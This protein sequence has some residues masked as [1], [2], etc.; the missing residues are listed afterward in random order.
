MPELTAGDLLGGCRVEGVIARGG[1]GI[2]YRA[3]QL[4][5]QRPVALKVIAGH[6][7]EDPE[8]RQRFGRESRM[9]AAIDHPNVVPVYAA[10][11]DRGALYIVMRFVPG[12]DLHALIKSLGRLP[13]Q[14][15]A[16]I[17]AQVA[18]ALDAAHA[19]GLVHRDVKPAN[20]LLAGDDHAYLGDFGLM[21]ALDPDAPLTDTGDWMGTVDFAAPEQLSGERVDARSDVYSLGC[22]LFAALTGAP[23][24]QRGTVPA[25]LLAH[26]HDPPPRPS[27]SG[28]PTHF[29]RV[30][31]R[32]LAKDPEDRYPSAG[33]LGRAA[34]AAARGEPVTE[35]ERTVAIGPAAPNGDGR[36]EPTAPTAVVELPR[37]R[38]L[39][40]AAPPADRS[41]APARA[42]AATPAAVATPPAAAADRRTRRRRFRRRGLAAA[43]ALPLAG[44][45]TVATLMLDADSERGVATAQSNPLAAG[46]VRAAVDAFAQA[47]ESEDGRALRRLLSADVRRVLPAGS[48]RGRDAVATEYESQ[49]RTNATQ[50]Y[51]LEDLDVR[52]GRAG[53][54]SGRYRVRRAGAASIT[55]RIVLGVIRERGRTQIALIT[56]TPDG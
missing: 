50:S 10:G 40:P 17:V 2:V 27:A 28:A 20:V 6:H 29:D 38:A 54:A 56:V 48:V 19:A 22:V 36:S 5:L 16:A 7:A 8:F 13:A 35:S 18:S 55:G 44:I 3:V 41:P 1:M 25:T 31:A 42:A 33:D 26:L 21:R 47:Y 32:A 11:E 39:T 52:G 9:A 24:F 43:L 45:A 15:A 14:R 4:D 53:R 12:S 46:E 51:G 49:F 34:L 23:P 37:S 30:V